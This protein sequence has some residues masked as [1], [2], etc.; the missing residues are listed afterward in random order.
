[1]TRALDATT[2]SACH[3]CLRRDTDACTAAMSIHDIVDVALPD[4]DRTDQTIVIVEL[5]PPSCFAG[6]A[7][8]VTGDFTAWAPVPLDRVPAGGFRLGVVARRGARLRYRFVADEGRPTID[9]P[10]L[11]TIPR[12]T[13]FDGPE[14][15]LL[16]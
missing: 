6:P 13:T 3:I 15:A 4:P 10:G 2:S 1:M 14:S 16:T 8:A 9:G 11:S 7:L 12:S 5:R